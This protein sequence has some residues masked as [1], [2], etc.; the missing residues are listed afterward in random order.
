MAGSAS[1]LATLACALLIVGAL[2][3]RRSR[4]S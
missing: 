2:R 3:R 4:R 1:P